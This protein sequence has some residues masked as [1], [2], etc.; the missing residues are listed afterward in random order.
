RMLR[1]SPV[2]PV[3]G[4]GDNKVQPVAVEDVA[5]CFVGAVDSADV[6]GRVFD[7]CGEEEFTFNALLETI[8]R[9]AGKRRMKVHVPFAAAFVL[10]YLMGIV[11][12]GVLRMPPPLNREQLL[13]LR[14]DNTGDPIPAMRMFRFE[15]K[16][17]APAI[18]AY[19]R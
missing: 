10:A 6:A 5:H 7:L 15:P 8:M 14:E 17:M 9:A 11:Y 3:F 16:R 2:L 18:E 1:Y 19:L 12:R 13:M 4:S